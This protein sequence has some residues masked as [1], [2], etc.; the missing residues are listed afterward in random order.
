M[1]TLFILGV[2]FMAAAV[3]G[4]RLKALGVQV[5][6]ITTRFGRIGLW[7]TGVVAIGLGVL[8]HYWE[9][10]WPPASA[11]ASASSTPI[12]EP[13]GPSVTTTQ[14]AH[15]TDPPVDYQAAVTFSYGKVDG[16]LDLDFNPPRRVNGHNINQPISGEPVLGADSDVLLAEWDRQ[17][18]PTKQQCAD[19]L[20][21]HG[22]AQTGLLVT[23]NVVCVRTAQGRIA[24]L[25]LTSTN[26]YQIRADATI[27]KN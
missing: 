19:R 7:L 11:A 12:V 6:I 25:I 5:S 21:H 16:A 24:R 26:N 20:A 23:G 1:I 3:V 13:G 14:G 4:G 9:T 27:W 17:D 15:L 22:V 2:V 18:N 8:A 10:G